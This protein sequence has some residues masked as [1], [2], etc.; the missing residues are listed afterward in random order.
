LGRTPD[1]A[2]VAGGMEA[3]SRQALDNLKAVLATG[4]AKLT[5]VLRLEVYVA[6]LAEMPAF[7]QVFREYFPSDPPARVGVEAARLAA[8]AR[9]ELT[10]VAY[11]G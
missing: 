2:M 11:C 10:A 7:N 4:G 3:E 8:G 6:D 9:I 1:G 5:D